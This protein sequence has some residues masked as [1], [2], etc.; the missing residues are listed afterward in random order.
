[1][2]VTDFTCAKSDTAAKAQTTAA[3]EILWIAFITC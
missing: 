2:T 3:N 1:M